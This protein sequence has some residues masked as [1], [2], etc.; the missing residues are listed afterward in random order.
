[1][2]KE[3]KS[4]K[5]E[6]ERLNDLI[7]SR[8][9]FRSV[10]KRNSDK[11]ARRSYGSVNKSS[12][13]ETEARYDPHEFKLPSIKKTE[14]NVRIR[15]KPTIA[16]Q[17]IYKYIYNQGRTQ[18]IQTTGILE[19][20]TGEQKRLEDKQKEKARAID[21]LRDLQRIQDHNKLKLEQEL[22]ELNFERGKS[23]DKV[24]SSV[25]GNFLRHSTENA[26]FNPYSVS[27]LICFLF[28]TL[29]YL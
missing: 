6:F 9:S 13:V 19:R 17:H 2:L 18:I 29:L 16:D 5:S 10:S 28:L 21:R 1:M 25:R 12:T 26:K 20:T 15:G 14:M 24:P 3:V 23:I 11:L 8:N 4:T 27:S 7:Q 22:N